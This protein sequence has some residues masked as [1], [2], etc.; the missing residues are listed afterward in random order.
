MGRREDQGRRKPL[1]MEPHRG[2]GGSIAVSEGPRRLGAASP[3]PNVSHA[4]LDEGANPFCHKDRCIA[5]LTLANTM[6]SVNTTLRNS[7]GT[8]II[9]G[10]LDCAKAEDQ[11]CN[12][13][14]GA[15]GAVNSENIQSLSLRTSQLPAVKFGDRITLQPKIA[16]RLRYKSRSICVDPDFQFRLVK[17]SLRG[18]NHIEFILN[19]I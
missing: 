1:L 14:K 2:L 10:G 18:R 15:A 7:E 11:E 13:R 4:P 8:S 5:R 3:G 6:R 12:R 19:R 9:V 16:A 17:T